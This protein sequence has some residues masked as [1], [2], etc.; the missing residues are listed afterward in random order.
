[1]NAGFDR[2]AEDVGNLVALEHV[3]LAVPERRAGTLFY[4][5]AMGFTRDPFLMVDDENMW[6][7]V[8]R[9]QFHL[10]TGAPQLLRGAIGIVV[11]DP[12]AL[13]TRLE[14]ARAKLAGT[15]F[16]F[17]EEAGA[18][19]VTCP[20]GNRLRCHA[21]GPRFPGMTLGI[22][23]VELAVRP[24][25]A[26]GI[27]RFYREVM[28]AR[29][30]L[31][32]EHAVA[33]VAVGANQALVFRETRTPPPAYDGHHIAIYVTDFSGPHRFLK[34]HDLVTE[35]S[36]EHQY[37]FQDIF[38]LDTGTKLTELEHEVRSLRHPMFGREL[39]NRNPAQSNR[40]YLR[41]ADRFEC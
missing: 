13:R 15:G 40:N 41:G 29:C 21:P 27:A 7:N 26:A 14:A 9:Q 25:A 36:G 6:V 2:G 32:E 17:A 8:G 35:E 3:N 20:W 4:V 18:L 38:D 19:V 5:S 30:G 12:A 37:R 23:Y 31:S 1:M 39:V 16:G 33:S 34:Q 28:G 10:P 24:G 22:A 11:P